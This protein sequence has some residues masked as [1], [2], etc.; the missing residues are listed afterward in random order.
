[1]EHTLD[2]CVLCGGY[3]TIQTYVPLNSHHTL[4]IHVCEKCAKM[5]EDKIRIEYKNRFKRT[6]G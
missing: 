2:F 1:M 3:D 6:R 4:W 5:G